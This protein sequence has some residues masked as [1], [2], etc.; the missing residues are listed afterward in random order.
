MTSRFLKYQKNSQNQTF[1]KIKT[2]QKSKPKTP[3]ICE[4]FAFL[5]LSYIKKFSSVYS[6]SSFKV[7]AF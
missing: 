6:I 4:L 2:E 3:I 5:M 1:G 7:Y